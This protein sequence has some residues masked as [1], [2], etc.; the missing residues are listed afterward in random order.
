MTVSKLPICTKKQF[1]FL[2]AIQVCSQEIVTSM[3]K[4]LNLDCNRIN[5]DHY[6]SPFISGNCLVREIQIGFFVIQLRSRRPYRNE[7]RKL[8]C[9][10]ASTTLLP[11]NYLEYV[12]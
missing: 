11:Y 6:F 4:N 8:K 12:L 5:T 10:I 9:W 1:P 3:E 2:A 7:H